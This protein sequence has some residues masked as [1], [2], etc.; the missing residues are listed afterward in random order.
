MTVRDRELFDSFA[1]TVRPSMLGIAKRLCRGNGID[2]EDVVHDALERVLRSYR[3]GS[4]VDALTTAFASTVMTHLLI[5]MLRRRRNLVLTEDLPDAPGEPPGEEEERWRKVSDEQV[6]RGIAAL[7]PPR[8]REAYE[9]HARGFRYRA[10]AGKLHIAEGTVGADLTE[11][12]RQL[13]KSL[14]VLPPEEG[15]GESPRCRSVARERR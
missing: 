9:F 12:R 2:P 3:D 10:I 15:E 5:D 6:Q 7:K 14:G 8:I 11:A 4:A 13:R 1:R